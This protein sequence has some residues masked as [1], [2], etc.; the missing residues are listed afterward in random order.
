MSWSEIGNMA[1]PAAQALAVVGDRWTMLI[2]RELF[3]GAHRFEEFQAQ[4]GMS[5][6]LL[7]VRLKRLLRD[8]LLERRRY[9][10]R[11]PRYEYVLTEK[12]RDL[13]PVMLG[14]KAWGEKWGVIDTSGPSGLTII[15]KGCGGPTTLELR[16]S[17]CGEPFGP[18][19]ARLSMGKGF[20]EE[21]SRR[22]EE[23]LARRAGS[24]A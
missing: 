7:S 5:S 9:N 17:S 6:H 21:R 4:T 8:G 18:R 2:L 23:F 12:G 24:G 3:L 11:P 16:C 13:Y 14:L 20:E 15:H 19:D 22:R 1:C 10:E